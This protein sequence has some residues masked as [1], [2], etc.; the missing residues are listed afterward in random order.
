MTRSESREQAFILNFEAQFSSLPIEEIIECV[1][2]YSAT[3]ITNNQEILNKM[4]EKNGVRVMT[5]K[6]AKGLEFKNVI[7]ID[8]NLSENEKYVA[9]TRSLNDSIIYLM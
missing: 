6:E 8:D 7:V 4:K 1:K 3:V 2:N 5:V 9:Y